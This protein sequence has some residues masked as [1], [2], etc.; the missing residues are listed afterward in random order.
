MAVPGA[1][2]SSVAD[3]TARLDYPDVSPDVLEGAMALM[4]LRYGAN[5]SGPSA[6]FQ[7][8]SE[9]VPSR[10]GQPSQDRDDLSAS[11]GQQDLQHSVVTG[12][13]PATTPPCPFQLSHT[14]SRTNLLP[15]EG[16]PGPESKEKSETPSIVGNESVA[17][18]HKRV[19]NCK[20]I[21][22]EKPLGLRRAIRRRRLIRRREDIRVRQLFSQLIKRRK[23]IR[24]RKLNNLLNS[25]K[26]LKSIKPPEGG[27]CVG[28]GRSKVTAHSSIPEGSPRE[29]DTGSAAPATSGGLRNFHQDLLA[30]L[31]FSFA[32]RQPYPRLGAGLDLDSLRASLRFGVA[33]AEDP[34]QH[35]EDQTAQRGSSDA[36]TENQ[37]ASLRQPIEEDFSDSSTDESGGVSLRRPASED[38]GDC[39]TEENQGISL[40]GGG[41]SPRMP[42]DIGPHPGNIRTTRQYDFEHSIRRKLG[43]PGVDIVR[44]EEY[45]LKGIQLILALKS[46]VR[47]PIKTY[48]AAAVFYHRFRLKHLG[49]QHHWRDGAIACLFLACKAE[50][51]QKKSRE[52]LCAN[53][54]MSHSDKKTPDDKPQRL[55]IGLERLVIESIH[56]DFRVR[57]PQDILARLVKKVLP[58]NDDGRNFFPAAFQVLWD[59]HMTY[60]PIKQTSH[61]MALAVSEVT[62]LLTG[63]HVEKFRSLDPKAHCTDRGSV[64]ETILD[65]LDLYENHHDMTQ[66]GKQFPLETFIDLKILVNKELEEKHLPRY[67]F[68]C[69]ECEKNPEPTSDSDDP[70]IAPSGTGQGDGTVRYVFDTAQADEELDEVRKHFE[71]DYEFYEVE[72]EEEIPDS[73]QPAPRDQPRGPRG[74]R[75]HSGPRGRRGPGGSS[76]GPAGSTGGGV[77]PFPRGPRDTGGPPR[78]PSGGGHNPNWRP[79]NRQGNR[80]RRD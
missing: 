74:P 50:D 46:E 71:D 73:P 7:P 11:T 19:R 57:H 39:P 62:A 35:S 18:P 63:M 31:P 45:R 54:N 1:V 53:Y 72:E 80:R 4:V 70:D 65:I 66:F 26:F 79:R 49:T 8:I 27:K 75:G 55:I 42:P 6:D 25:I 16:I 30:A 38:S 67:K 22:R 51:T 44:E 52:I 2:D 37:G 24:A 5:G 10:A 29:A 33:F 56:F 69:A 78:G 23:D 77:E 20:L 21:R 48:V 12:H 47:L 15:R 58:D 17:K 9:R 60:A 34:P 3:V 68:R 40:R 64:T 61:T 14:E 36:F 43:Q 76:R 28:R 13:T 32:S 41:F 59:M